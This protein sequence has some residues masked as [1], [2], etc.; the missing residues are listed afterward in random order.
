MNYRVRP[1]CSQHQCASFLFLHAACYEILR[2]AET[3]DSF[4]SFHLFSCSISAFCG[5]SKQ[6]GA[7]LSQIQR[8]FFFWRCMNGR[9]DGRTPWWR[10]SLPGQPACLAAFTVQITWV[11][12]RRRAELQSWGRRD[13]RRGGEERRGEQ[14]RG[15]D[16]E[17]KGEERLKRE[18]ERRGGSTLVVNKPYIGGRT[19]VIWNIMDAHNISAWLTYPAADIK[20][21]AELFTWKLN[22][23]IWWDVALSALK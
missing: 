10:P 6:T 4:L 1:V 20:V 22:T 14:M 15:Q 11:E 21:P 13:C 17:R 19:E 23:M 8:P 9:G 5:F 16:E 18:K 7:M 2:A 3:A 12:E